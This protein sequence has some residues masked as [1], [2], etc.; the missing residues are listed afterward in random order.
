MKKILHSIFTIYVLA[1]T[2]AYAVPIQVG[3][4]AGSDAASVSSGISTAASVGILGLVVGVAI[5]AMGGDC[6][7]S[8]GTTTS[9]TAPSHE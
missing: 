4:P 7:S 6:C 3:E 5:T 1:T 9:T 8:T 2:S